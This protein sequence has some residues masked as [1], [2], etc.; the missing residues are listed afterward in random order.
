MKYGRW[1]RGK[2]VGIKIWRK[3]RMKES[4]MEK[5]KRVERDEREDRP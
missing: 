4:E 5:R 3:R 1:K 2:T